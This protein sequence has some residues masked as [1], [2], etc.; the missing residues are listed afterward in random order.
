MKEGRNPYIILLQVFTE[1]RW[2][3]QVTNILESL[4]QLSILPLESRNLLLVALLGLARHEPLVGQVKGLS[5]GQRYLLCQLVRDEDVACVL[6]RVLLL[7]D[8]TE[9]SLLCL[10]VSTVGYPKTQ[11]VNVCYRGS[12][13]KRG[14]V[15]L[16]MVFKP[17]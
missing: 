11:Q 16:N 13:R 1:S 15:L 5:D 9:E 12:R 14:K 2:L 10:V 6:V 3:Q 17:S 7:G 4:R 8:E